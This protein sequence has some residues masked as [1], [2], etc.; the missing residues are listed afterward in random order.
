[1]SRNY[2]LALSGSGLNYTRN[3][4]G[5]SAYLIEAHRNW[6]RSHSER[7]IPLFKAAESC[8][9]ACDDIG[10]ALLQSLFDTDDVHNRTAHPSDQ[11]I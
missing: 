6:I 2:K 8:L 5:S 11:C 10:D 3:M 9:Y 7:Y 4:G 1:V